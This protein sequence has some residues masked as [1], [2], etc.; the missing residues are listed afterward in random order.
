MH[1]ITK[2]RAL[3]DIRS[4]GVAAPQGEDLTLEFIKCVDFKDYYSYDR[5]GVLEGILARVKTVV[6]RCDVVGNTMQLAAFPNAVE[7]VY[8][9]GV[10]KITRPFVLVVT[11]P[12]TNR[13]DGDSDSAAPAVEHDA[14]HGM[15]TPQHI[16][17]RGTFSRIT[18]VVIGP[19]VKE[20]CADAFMGW[21]K[22][23]TIELHEGL[24]AISSNAFQ[25]CTHLRAITLPDS[26]TYIG[27]YAFAETGLTEISLPP[28]AIT[29]KHDDDD[30]DDNIR[31]GAT[32]FSNCTSLVRC[33]I[34]G[35]PTTL[36]MYIFQGCTALR[37]VRLPQSITTI[38]HGAFL[39]CSALASI[40]LPDAVEIIGDDAF[41]S[42]KALRRIRFPV[43]LKSLGNRCFIQSGL[44]HV[45]M[46][47][48]DTYCTHIGKKCFAAC[49]NL[50]CVV[51]GA[52]VTNIN[53]FAFRNNPAL[54]LVVFKRQIHIIPTSHIFAN[55]PN[56]RL[57][58]C[59][60]WPQTEA[61]TDRMSPRS[62]EN[63]TTHHHAL[64]PS[65]HILVFAHQNPLT[66]FRGLAY[67]S[68]ATVHNSE[69]ATSVCATILMI[70]ARLCHHPHSP[71][72][73]AL[74]SPDA[75]ATAAA[76]A[77]PP[78]PTE[79]WLAIIAMLKWYDAVPQQ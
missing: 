17:G 14:E 78:L 1:T 68:P 64:T 28:N 32:A 53:N 55:C 46:S 69:A 56:M 33:V 10:T 48:A 27:R 52:S 7:L 75:A 22:L 59:P 70:A 3:R 8:G 72:Y 24:E 76:S 63:Y 65:H 47:P 77:L 16:P 39:D 23:A 38:N 18:R 35:T 5:G 60:F 19:T 2:I 29:D 26:L 25:Y 45:D 13:E 31:G 12:T 4:K 79:M 11:H 61:L 41:C 54:A 66:V 51:V 21:R 6:L 36:G 58:V 43:N 34:R 57:I 49:P 9:E 20:I 30:D 42:C 50:V 37:S 71:R 73:R 67:I 44:T 74:T 62:V 15:S 40:V